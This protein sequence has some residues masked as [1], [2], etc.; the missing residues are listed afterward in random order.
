MA[1]YFK[2]APTAEIIIKHGRFKNG[3]YF[4]QGV[5]ALRG[6]V[7]PTHTNLT[8]R[9]PNLAEPHPNRCALAR[10]VVPEQAKDFGRRDIQIKILHC[11][12]S[13]EILADISQ[14]NHQAKAG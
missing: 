11:H 10:A 12:S 4:L 8:L 13:V 2:I 1:Q 14:L 9:G 6:H 7:E 3:P 5:L